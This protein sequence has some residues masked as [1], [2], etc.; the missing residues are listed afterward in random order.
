MGLFEWRSAQFSVAQALQSVWQGPRCRA[1]EGWQNHQDE[2]AACPATELLGT[3]GSTAPSA[4]GVEAPSPDATDE[5][6][7]E[8][9]KCKIRG[10]QSPWSRAAKRSCSGKNCVLRATPA[11]SCPGSASE[12]G[13][14]GGASSDG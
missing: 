12:G 2:P 3:A 1:V 11:P 7:R 6:R 5:D 10:P 9:W 4:M 14:G 8:Q 13:Q